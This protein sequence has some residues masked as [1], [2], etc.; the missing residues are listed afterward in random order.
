MP[1]YNFAPPRPDYPAASVAH[2]SSAALSRPALVA[3]GM[4][5]GQRRALAVLQDRWRAAMLARALPLNR[6]R[7]ARLL[8]RQTTACRPPRPGAAPSRE[9]SRVALGCAAGPLHLTGSGQRGKAADAAI[10]P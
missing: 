5:L 4:V 6:E 1:R 2:L 10:L 9:N 8:H 3:L 7:T